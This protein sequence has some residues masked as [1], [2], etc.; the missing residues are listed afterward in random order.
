MVRVPTEEGREFT[1]EDFGAPPE[2]RHALF[3][4]HAGPASAATALADAIK[5]L[6]PED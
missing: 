3:Y 2:M 6:F 5:S 1:W 4:D